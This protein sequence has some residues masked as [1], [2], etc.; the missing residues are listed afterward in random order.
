MSI[1]IF[2]GHHPT[3]P[4]AS[5][6]GFNEHDEA[7]RWLVLLR[8]F[9]EEEDLLIGPVGPLRNKT[10][11]INNRQPVLCADLHFN[12]APLGSDGE[13]RGEGCETLYYPGSERGK[14]AA[15]Y[16]QN[17]LSEVF[18]PDRG[19]KE[20]YYR[21]DPSRGADWFLARTKTTAL[22][23]EPEF[24]HQKEKIVEKRKE[25]VEALALGLSAAVNDLIV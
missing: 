19:V 21:M 7:L 5:W 18:Q 12:S 25:G 3:R 17:A 9:F 24:I 16:V 22:I 2:A 6:Y 11:F 8:E 14:I 23:L 4:G 20:G 1:I 10:E 15:E 13:P